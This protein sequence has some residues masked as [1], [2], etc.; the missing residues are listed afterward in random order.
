MIA[1]S[2]ARRVG[3]F[4]ASFNVNPF[5]LRPARRDS[6]REAAWTHR[7]RSR[8]VEFGAEPP[9]SLR[10]IYASFLADD[11]MLALPIRERPAAASLH[12][13][14]PGPGPV[15]AL[16]RAG[17]LPLAPVT[18]PAQARKAERARMDAIVAQ[19]WKAG[20]HRGMVDPDAPDDRPGVLVRQLV[21]DGML[22]VIA[23]GGIMDAAAI[24]AVLR[25]EAAAAQL[26]ADVS[27]VAA[28]SIRDRS[29]AARLEPMRVRRSGRRSP[30]ARSRRPFR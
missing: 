2:R 28:D 12:V 29:S 24:D 9:G 7:L 5:A 19:G 1:E 27:D 17:I 3:P 21:R 4:A 8:F 14:L 16:R 11:A 25:L 23:A 10:E 30:P 6:G 15:R 26:V 20:D 13:G 22:P 18:S